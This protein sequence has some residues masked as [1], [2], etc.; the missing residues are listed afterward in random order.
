[1]TLTPLSL[2]A[3]V[4]VQSEKLGFDMDERQAATEAELS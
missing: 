2:W 3:D 1:M 4:L